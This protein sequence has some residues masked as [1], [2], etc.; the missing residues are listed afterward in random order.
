MIL[1]VAACFVFAM[2]VTLTAYTCEIQHHGTSALNTVVDYVHMYYRR[3]YYLLKVQWWS[4]DNNKNKHHAHFETR[5][6]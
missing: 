4:N 1:A 6:M 3:P 2:I 5:M